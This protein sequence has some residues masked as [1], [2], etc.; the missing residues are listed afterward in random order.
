MNNN[1]EIFSLSKGEVFSLDKVSTSKRFQLR[2][3][4]DA[5]MAGPKT[6]VDITA[7]ICNDNDQVIEKNRTCFVFYNNLQTPDGSIIH[8]GDEREGNK[9]GWDEVIDFDFGIMRKDAQK[10]PLILSI[11]KAEQE[12]LNFGQVKN[13]KVDIFDVDAQKTIAEF[14]PNM[15]NS[16]D[17]TMIVGEFIFRNGGV[18]F[19]ALGK[20]SKANLFTLLTEYG[21][22][23]K[24]E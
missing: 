3:K 2:A 9:V 7:L 5:S 1:T 13:L 15:D 6:D 4:W 11:D 8:S 23:L 14:E 22:V 10:L 19:K 17:I 12:G 21:I 20:G 18:S 24:G 16:I